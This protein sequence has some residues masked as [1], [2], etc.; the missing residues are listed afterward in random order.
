LP[1]KF[2]RKTIV[3]DPGHGGYDFGARGPDGTFE[4][5]V[6]M[7]LGRILELELGNTYKVTLTR[8]DDYWTDIHTR[9][10][11]ANHLNADMFISIHTGGSFL[12]Q[13]SGI[14][15]YY[16]K[17][18]SDTT[19]ML[20][21]DSSQG[22]KDTN[23]QTSWSDTQNRHQQTSKVLAEI[24]LNRMNEPAQFKTE[25]QGVPLMVLEGADMP[26]VLIEVGYI[27][28]PA[29]EKML[30]DIDSLSD[31]AKKIKRGIDDFFEK[32]P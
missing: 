31:I 32:V 24:L 23:S 12:H 19:L 9:T 11:M 20:G 3:I 14:S 22:F 26:A 28:N 13:A 1:F 15:L 30:K 7:E 27:T 25:I 18:I 17:K 10:S 5:T 4:K 6:T 29:D 16:Y 2:Q 8:T 21:Q